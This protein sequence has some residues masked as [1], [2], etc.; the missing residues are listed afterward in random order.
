[1][2]Y[3]TTKAILHSDIDEVRYLNQL[4]ILETV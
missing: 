3:D 2:I 1:M 4:H